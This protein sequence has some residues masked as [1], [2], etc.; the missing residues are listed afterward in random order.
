MTGVGGKNKPIKQ[1]FT[2]LVYAKLLA[3]TP[4]RVASRSVA[5]SRMSKHPSAGTRRRLQSQMSSRFRTIGSASSPS[6][7]RH[8][9]QSSRHVSSTSN[10]SV[11]G[12]APAQQPQ[13][14]GQGLQQS[15]ELM[16]K[17][18]ELTGKIDKMGEFD[19]GPHFMYND[20]DGG[21]VDDMY[22]APTTSLDDGD[23]DGRKRLHTHGVGLHSI[24]NEAGDDNASLAEVVANHCNV[25]QYVP[26]VVC[27]LCGECSTVTWLCFVH[28]VDVSGRDIHTRMTPSSSPP[29]PQVREGAQEPGHP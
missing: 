20:D 12:L 7:Y 3:A 11:L 6:P 9:A 8:G 17:L 22:G 5:P 29:L 13:Q 28:V 14:Q 4:R 24:T 2:E 18:A 10:G 15:A 16:R 19:G 25:Y 1:N 26:P 27:V 23:M 21:A